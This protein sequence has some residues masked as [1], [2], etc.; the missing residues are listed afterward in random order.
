MFTSLAYQ[1][2]K[3]KKAYGYPSIR[4]CH[5]IK[6]VQSKGFHSA[7]SQQHIMLSSA[8]FENKQLLYSGNGQPCGLDSCWSGLVQCIAKDIYVV[9]WPACVIR[10]TD[11]TSEFQMGDGQLALAFAVKKNF[12]QDERCHSKNGFVTHKRQFIDEWSVKNEV[13]QIIVTLETLVFA[14]LAPSVPPTTM[15]GVWTVGLRM[16]YSSSCSVHE[17]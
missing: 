13:D 6:M 16:L 4:H 1:L 5:C 2:R 7:L 15:Y 12:V 10:Y 17:Q 14:A 9:H 3:P 11:I 8:S